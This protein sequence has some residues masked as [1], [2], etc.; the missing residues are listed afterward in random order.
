MPLVEKRYAEALAGLSVKYDKIDLY[1]Q[2]LGAVTDTYREQPELKEFLLNPQTDINTKKDALRNIFGNR[3]GSN[4]LN[5]LMLLLDKGRIGY[6]PGIYDEF[7]KLADQNRGILNIDIISAAPLE[8]DQL[9]MIS[10]QYGKLY[11][12]AAVKIETKLDAS[13]IGGIKI[14]IGDK[15]VDGT[16]KGRLKGLQDMLSVG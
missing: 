16:V 9:N 3:L 8:P 4:I 12:A 7:V 13:L 11:N 1:Q 5:F 15:L 2:E 6:L 10:Q 14:K